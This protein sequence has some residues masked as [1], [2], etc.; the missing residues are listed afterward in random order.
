MY[1]EPKLNMSGL[2]NTFGGRTLKTHKIVD[3]DNALR[4]LPPFGTGHNGNIYAEWVL[5]WGYVDKNAK[6]KPLVC[7]KKFEKYCPIC[8]E[9]KLLFDRK[10]ALVGEF[11]DAKGDIN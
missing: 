6:V 2:A 11:K 10:A 9:S 1:E 3:G 8:E 4:I 5:H 7:T